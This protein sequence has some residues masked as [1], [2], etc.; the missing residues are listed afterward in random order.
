M[1]LLAFGFLVGW[2]WV[3]RRH[4]LDVEDAVQA[5]GSHG[6]YLLVVF[7]Q[8][9]CVRELPCQVAM[10]CVKAMSLVLFEQAELE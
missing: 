10:S 8:A 5:R 3:G 7:H 6:V 2:G 1:R 4:G 9:R